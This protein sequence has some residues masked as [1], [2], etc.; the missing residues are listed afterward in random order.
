MKGVRLLGSLKDIMWRNKYL[1]TA[2]KVKIYKTIGRPVLT[3]ASETL[4]GYKKG[5][6]AINIYKNE[7]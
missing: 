3:Y 5:K 6:V 4:S 2:S 7:Q 1:L